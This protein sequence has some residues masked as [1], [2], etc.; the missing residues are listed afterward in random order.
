MTT[1]GQAGQ[2]FLH[3]SQDLLQCAELMSVKP[4]ASIKYLHTVVYGRGRFERKS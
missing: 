1:L 4:S 2:M 3:Q